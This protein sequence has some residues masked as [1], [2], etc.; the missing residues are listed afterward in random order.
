MGGP[1]GVVTEAPGSPHLGSTP[2][3]MTA[4]QAGSRVE[5]GGVTLILGQIREASE[6]ETMAGTETAW[7]TAPT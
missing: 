6:A 2:G 7:G 4:P 1:G 5:V 3:G